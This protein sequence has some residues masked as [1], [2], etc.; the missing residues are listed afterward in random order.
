MWAKSSP[1]Y[2]VKSIEFLGIKAAIV[3][4]IIIKKKIHRV[5]KLFFINSFII[6]SLSKIIDTF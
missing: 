3:K 4:K 2:G 6:K 1:P 5:I